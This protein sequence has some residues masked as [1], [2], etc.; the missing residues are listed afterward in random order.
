MNVAVII[1]RNTWIRHPDAAVE[2][3][4]KLDVDK[5]EGAPVRVVG[6]IRTVRGSINY[7][8]REFTLKTGVISF[9]GGSKIDPSLD[10]DAQYRVTNYIVDIVVGGTASKPT[11][12]LR[13]QPEL[14]QADILSL[15]LFGKTTDALGQGQQASLQQQASKMA[16]GIAA[17][18]IG[19]AVS[20]SMGLQSMGVTLNDT[21]SGGP[22]VGIGHYLGENTYVSASESM[23]GSGQKVSVQYFFLPW[24]SVTTSS[25]ADG[26]HEID[27]NLVKQY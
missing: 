12:Q 22:G 3:E 24:L 16:T 2:L 18:Q 1:H 11:L 20:S 14:A 10:M 13:S 26:S 5:D 7:Y 17:R 19:Q 23:G 25:A 15:I 4:G 8:Q 9:T 6:E 27:L 21:S